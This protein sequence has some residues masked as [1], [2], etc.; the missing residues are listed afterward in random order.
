[1]LLSLMG[2][3]CVLVDCGFDVRVEKIYQTASLR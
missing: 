3:L 1:M 2:C